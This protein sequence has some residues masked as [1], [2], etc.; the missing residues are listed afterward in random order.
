MGMTSDAY[1]AQLGALTPRGKLWSSLGIDALFSSLLLALADFFARFDADVDQHGEE[2]DPRTAAQLLPEWEWTTGLPDGCLGDGGSLAQRRNAVVSRL[3]ATG[4]SS[5]AYFIDQAAQFGYAITISYPAF[6]TWRASTP[7][8]V[9]LVNS[10]C[11]GDCNDPLQSYGNDQLEC[12]LN[13]IKPAHTVLQIAYG[14]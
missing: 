9:S 1:A 8:A 13:R 6:N 7:T 2:S 12:L 5:E 4:G 3:T 11:N 14:V 10:T